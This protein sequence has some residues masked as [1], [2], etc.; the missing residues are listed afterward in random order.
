[1]YSLLFVFLLGCEDSRPDMCVIVAR[2][3]LEIRS[4][5]TVPYGMLA[6]DSLRCKCDTVQKIKLSLFKNQIALRHT[7]TLA[8]DF[9]FFFF[10]TLTYIM[11]R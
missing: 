7:C 11:C 8:E 9:F 10:N 6:S 4:G 5:P 2:C 1:M 3:M